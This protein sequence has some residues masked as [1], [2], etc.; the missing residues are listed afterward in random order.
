MTRYTL[1]TPRKGR[2]E[3]S[4]LTFALIVIPMILILLPLLIALTFLPTL[5]AVCVLSNHVA[6]EHM[7]WLIVGTIIVQLI[8]FKLFVKLEF[9]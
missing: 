4:G 1:T 2:R 3:V 8:W 9:R 7:I 5:L 6:D